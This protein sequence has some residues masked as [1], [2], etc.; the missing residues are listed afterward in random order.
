MADNLVFVQ[1][2]SLIRSEAFT[3]EQPLSADTR[4]A[5]IEGWDSFKH[6]RFL[7]AVED[8][9]G[10]EVSPELGETLET[11]GDLAAVVPQP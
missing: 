11:L 6:L 9:F 1:L 4:F 5:D 8:E 2:V 10:F 3:V 7:L